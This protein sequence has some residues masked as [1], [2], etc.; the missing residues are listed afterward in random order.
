MTDIHLLF[1]SGLAGAGLGCFFYQGLWLT[2]RRLPASSRPHRLLLASF[3]AR[4]TVVMTGL[5]L[6]AGN[7]PIQLVTALAAF[8][9]VR[10]LLVDRTKKT[11]T[12]LGDR[13]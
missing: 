3:V 12:A 13:V 6:C 7:G 5:Y 9:L 2:V 4:M 10:F 8:F 1:I 11:L